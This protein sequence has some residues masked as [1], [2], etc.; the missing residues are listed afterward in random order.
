MD[1]TF[2]PSNDEE[3][4]EGEDSDEDY[5]SET[6]DSSKIAHPLPLSS[7]PPGPFRSTCCL[8]VK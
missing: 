3:A 1:E 5:D 2:N 7:C 4:E 8:A 6:E